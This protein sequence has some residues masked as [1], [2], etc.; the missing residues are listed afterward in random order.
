[1]QS[2]LKYVPHAEQHLSHAP[3]QIAACA[4]ALEK[5][6]V[7]ASYAREKQYPPVIVDLIVENKVS[8]YVEDLAVIMTHIQ[9]TCNV[10][11]RHSEVCSK[12]TDL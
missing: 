11:Q 10:G 9:P 2:V 5:C 3:S 6:T 8:S 1:M 4:V 12:F 7:I